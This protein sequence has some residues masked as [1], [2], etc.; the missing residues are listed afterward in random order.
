MTVVEVGPSLGVAAHQQQREGAIPMHCR[1]GSA[2]NRAA[3]AIGRFVEPAAAA[4]QVSESVQGARVVGPQRQDGAEVGFGAGKIAKIA[5]CIAAVAARGYMARG[6]P[7]HGV[8]DTFR[9][10]QAGRPV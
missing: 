3:Q 5:A 1:G 7:E 8:V 6:L 10:G 4:Q 9:L 2:G